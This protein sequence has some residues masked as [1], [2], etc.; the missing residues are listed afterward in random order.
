MPTLGRNPEERSDEGSSIQRALKTR[1]ARTA[2]RAVS[3]LLLT[4]LVQREGNWVVAIGLP[5]SRSLA[6]SCRKCCFARVYRR[7]GNEISEGGFSPPGVEKARVSG[8]VLT[9]TSEA[10]N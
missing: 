4:M 2:R 5:E 3:L 8:L 7:C 6:K 9:F 10:P 1:S